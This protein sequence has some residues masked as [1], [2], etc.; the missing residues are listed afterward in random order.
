M[1]C[2]EI[3]FD[4][5]N[6]F[7][8][9]YVLPMFCIKKSFWQR[10]TC[11]ETQNL[12]KAGALGALCLA[13]RGTPAV[14]W[15]CGVCYVPN[16]SRISFQSCSKVASIVWPRPIHKVMLQFMKTVKSKP[17]L[18]IGTAKAIC[19]NSLGL[20]RD[21]SLNYIFFKNKLLFKIENWKF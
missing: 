4:I 20:F 14:L 21:Y 18:K 11:T 9:K 17:L 2:T 7:C 10:F 16:A 19:W 8:T 3:V 6:N 12:D 15:K 13:S 1:L 5:Q